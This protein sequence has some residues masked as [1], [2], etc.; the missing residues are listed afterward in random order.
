VE[1]A[2]DLNDDGEINVT[3][4]VKVV[5][6]I[7]SGNNV[8]QRS[9]MAESTDHD[10]LTL[11]ENENHT[12]SLSLDNEGS[13]VATQFDIHLS[14]G[15]TL[16]DISLN[17][18]RSNEHVLTYSKK[19]ANTYRVIVY[20]LDNQA[21]AGNSGELLSVHISGTG[22]VEA[23]NI[24]FVTSGQ[25]EKRFEPMYSYISTAIRAIENTESMDV[26]SVDGRQVRKQV[27]S[28]DDL[29]KGIYIINGKK[30]I[31]R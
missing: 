28:T 9:A 1:A 21:Y 25:N 4:I 14:A 18:I 12:L 16:E 19:D 31:V 6:I 8:R 27:M 29:K 15:Q 11:T 7:M 20:S 30:H 13:Y 24:L 10:R 2:A 22:H 17:D 3:D 23:D 5:S 26:Y